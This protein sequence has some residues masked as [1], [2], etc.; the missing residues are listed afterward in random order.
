MR[1]NKRHKNNRV[2]GVTLIELI[3][4][5]LVISLSLGALVMVFNQAANN[6]VD[7]VVRVRLLEIAQSHLDQVMARKYDEST[8]TGGIPACGTEGTSCAGIGLDGGEDLA[9]VGSLDD[10]DDFNNYA[11]TPI[12]GYSISIAVSL[13]GTELGLGANGD[14]KRITTTA[15]STTGASVVLTAYRTNF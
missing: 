3:V 6:S 15:T 13:A 1:I 11:A 2:K 8:P 7:P 12:T 10:V 5:I 4:F 9:V 14:A